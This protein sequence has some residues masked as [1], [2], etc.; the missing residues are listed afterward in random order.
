L[1]NQFALCKQAPPPWQE[2]GRGEAYST[3]G[4]NCQISHPEPGGVKRR[5]LTAGR[6]QYI[7]YRDSSAGAA[8]LRMTVFEQLYSEV[9]INIRLFF[10]K[11]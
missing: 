4:V 1:P 3:K 10:K 6:S 7:I 11:L 5:I 9:I 2:E 8:G